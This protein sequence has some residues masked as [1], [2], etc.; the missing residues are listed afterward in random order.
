M[1]PSS[2][3][4]A[5]TP[6]SSLGAVRP[7]AVAGLFYPGDAATLQ[8]EVRNL[9]ESTPEHLPAPGFPK[10]LIVPHAGYIYSGAVAAQAYDLLRPARG[11]VKRVV[12]LGPCH[13]VA[14]QGLAL[15]GAAAFATPYGSLPVD[16]EAAKRLLRLPYVTEFPA[17]HAQE[18]SLEVQLPFVHEVLGEVSILPLVVGAASAEQVVDVLERVWGGPETVI[19]IS[20]DLSHYQ[21]YDQARGVDG[22]TVEAILRGD[23]A[24]NHNQA[25]GAT[26]ISGMLQAAAR[27]NL[28]PRLLRYCNS[29]DTAGGRD[30]VVGYAAFAFGA[31][32][33][34]E[35]RHGRALLSLARAAIGAKLGLNPAPVIPDEPWLRERRASFVTLTLDGALRGCIGRLAAERPLGEDVADNARSSAF[36]DPRFKA[37]TPTEFQR[38]VVEV[39]VLSTPKRL[40]FT[41]HADLIRQL[42]P[43][44]DGLILEYPMENPSRRGTFLPSVWASLPDPEQ[45]ISQLKQKAGMLAGT[46][47]E[48]CRVLRYRAVKWSEGAG[49]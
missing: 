36:S 23:G 42:E 48:R 47:T 40:E 35:E 46:R 9:L 33:G 11:I 19:L 27:H 45:F 25:C 14:V 22:A 2:P 21:P 6:T 38:C 43:G 8:R 41:D 26:P 37:L 10:A 28:A 31:E 16:A 24:L 39:S 5:P 12:L 30:R 18:H 7:A 1:T 15:P 13:R 49:G 29:G 17:T 32:A 20:S 4:S 3:A 34:Y 44:R